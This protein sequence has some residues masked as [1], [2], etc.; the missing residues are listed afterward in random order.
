MTP[1]LAHPYGFRLWLR[2]RLPWW[3]INIGIA[4]KGKDCAAR[5]APHQWYNRDGANSAC[6]YCR[7]ER[8]GRLWEEASE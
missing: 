7:V 1:D 5:N 8:P 2:V 3:A 4:G 6:Y